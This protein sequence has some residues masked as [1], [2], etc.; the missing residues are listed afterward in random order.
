MAFRSLDVGR[1]EVFVL[2]V[3]HDADLHRF[4]L[5]PL[6][7][8]VC[9]GCRLLL[10]VHYLLV[11]LKGSGHVDAILLRCLRIAFA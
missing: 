2:H 7:S 6:P 5:R 4:S 11:T 1:R 3:L 10:L 8:L 9:L